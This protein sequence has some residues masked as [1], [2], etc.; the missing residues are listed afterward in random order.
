MLDI[1]DYRPE[2]QPDFARLN[3]EW[4]ERYFRVE[5]IDAEVLGDPDGRIIRGGGAILFAR[6]SDGVVGTCAL[7]HHGDDVYELTKMAV[8]ARAQG[9]GIGRALIAAAID[10]FRSLGGRRLYLETHDS[11]APAIGLYVSIGFEHAPRPDGPSVYERSNVYM[12]YRG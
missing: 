1:V 4:L 7:K 6:T 10:R 12:V 2:L 11:L 8:T 3:I 9:G 5:P